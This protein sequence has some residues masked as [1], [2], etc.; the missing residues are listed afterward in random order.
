[1]VTAVR[2]G[3]EAEFGQLVDR[4]RREL[5]VPCDRMMGGLSESEDMVQECLLRLGAAAPRSR[6]RSIL[7]A[8]LYRIATNVCLDELRKRPRRV[9]PYD[10]AP[11]TDL[12]AELPAPTVVA[13]IRKHAAVGE[14]RFLPTRANTQPAAAIYLR[15]SGDTHFRPLALEV[16]RF[17]DGQIA[18]I[19]DFPAALF[20]A[21]GLPAEL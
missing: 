15:R 3:S 10:A 21:F 7:R 4:H 6:G 1:M 2:S 20:P 13:S 8:L 16:L 12:T 9:L 5:Q 19:L 18:E 14:Y 17:V 11:T